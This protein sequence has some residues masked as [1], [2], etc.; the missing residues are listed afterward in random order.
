MEE[1]RLVKIVGF[2]RSPA[3]MA[4]QDDRFPLISVISTSNGD[5]DMTTAVLN[6]VA[7]E[8]Y[9]RHWRFQRH[10]VSL[11]M[12]QGSN[13][14]VTGWADWTPGDADV[15]G[16]PGHFPKKR[17]PDARLR[18]IGDLQRRARSIDRPGKRPITT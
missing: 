10:H 12:V 13:A 9:T 16:G 1:E 3:T 6:E 7:I 15:Y 18:I 8:N 5:I 11:V 2:D 4:I 14:G 17:N